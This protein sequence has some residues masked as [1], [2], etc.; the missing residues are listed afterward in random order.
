MTLVDPGREDGRLLVAPC[1]H[2]PSGSAD[3]EASMVEAW[4]DKEAAMM[5]GVNQHG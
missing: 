1:A 4:R 3:G 2:D 5:A